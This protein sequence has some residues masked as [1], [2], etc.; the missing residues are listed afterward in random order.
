MVPNQNTRNLLPNINFD[1]MVNCGGVPPPVSNHQHQ[2]LR[3][4][5][6]YPHFLVVLSAPCRLSSC[7]GQRPELHQRYLCLGGFHFPDAHF[8]SITIY[9]LGVFIGIQ[10]A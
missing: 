9:C 2:S 10:L 7:T 1:L 5:H 6:L 3:D 8:G 4:A